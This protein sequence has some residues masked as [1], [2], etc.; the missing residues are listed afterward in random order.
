MTNHVQPSYEDEKAAKEKREIQN[1][2]NREM[3][4]C[5]KKV[6]NRLE[7]EKTKAVPTP[8]INKII[9]PYFDRQH[10]WRDAINA[11]FGDYK[12]K[13]LKEI[14]DANGSRI[15]FT[16]VNTDMCYLTNKTPLTEGLDNI[17]ARQE[18]NGLKELDNAKLTKGYSDK[19]K[20]GELIEETSLD[21]NEGSGTDGAL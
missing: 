18:Y 15:A 20:S 4:E 5:R 1:R 9:K 16:D 17:S 10:T 6:L 13:I 3:K 7:N 8:E 19:V 12:Q 21:I 2:I 11:E 14:K